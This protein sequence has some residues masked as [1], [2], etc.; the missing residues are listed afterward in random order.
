MLSGAVGF[1]ATSFCSGRKLG[2][3]DILGT[4]VGGNQVGLRG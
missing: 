1:V 4:K 2:G 3:D